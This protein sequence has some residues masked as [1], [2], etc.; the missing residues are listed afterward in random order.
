VVLTAVGFINIPLFLKKIRSK[1]YK[2][3]STSEEIDFENM[4]PEAIK[5]KAIRRNCNG[6]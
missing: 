5:K 1:V 3:K 4:C 2:I 6:L